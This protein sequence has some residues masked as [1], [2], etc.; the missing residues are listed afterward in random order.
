MRRVG[1]RA[2]LVLL[3]AVLG[4]GISSAPQPAAR[5]PARARPVVGK[6]PPMPRPTDVANPPRVKVETVASGLVVPWGIAF[7][8]PDRIYVTERPGRVRVIENGKLRQAPYATISKVAA[9]SEGGLMGIAVD[10]Q[11][12]RTRHVYLMYTYRSGGASYNRVSVFDDTGSTLTN[13]RTLIDGIRGA[14]YHNGGVIRFGPD[15]FLYIGT[16]DGGRPASAQNLKSLNGKILR[17]GRDGK[18]APGNPFPRSPVYAYGFRNVQGLAWNPA[19]NALWATN[20]GPS[21]EFGLEAMD[22]VFVVRKGG[23]HGW[24]LSLGLTD[25]KGVSPPVLWFPRSAV[26]PAGAVFYRTRKIP[27]LDGNLLFASLRDEALYRVVLDG[28][29]S[30]SRIERWFGTGVHQGRLGRIRAV[31]QGPDAAIYISTSNRDG[32][33]PVHP[34]DDHIYRISAK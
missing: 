19:N 16:G 11:Y 32:R 29:R 4:C 5:R 8:S 31:V 26:P 6:R 7:P 27:M 10:P 22:S 23:N 34:N 1:I 15:D 30:I 2:V 24:P 14:P 17:I 28:P 13:E 20:H 18:P 33:G 9:S 3:C 21:G 25:V 12:S